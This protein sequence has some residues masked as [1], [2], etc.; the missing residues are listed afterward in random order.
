[1]SPNSGGGGLGG[2]SSWKPV[3]VCMSVLVAAN[4]AQGVGVQKP[5]EPKNAKH[6]D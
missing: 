3:G 6:C 4:G 1:M 5:K 2:F